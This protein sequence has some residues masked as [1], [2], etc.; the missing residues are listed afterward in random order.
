MKLRLKPKSAALL[1]F[2]PSYNAFWVLSQFA[3]HTLYTPSVTFMLCPVTQNQGKW[4]DFHSV[5]NKKT[6]ELALF[7]CFELWIK[8]SFKLSFYVGEIL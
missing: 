7:I 4:L 6:D 5:E 3:L 1:W 2:S 8:L